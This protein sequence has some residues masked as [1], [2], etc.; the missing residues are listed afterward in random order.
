MAE[1][2]GRRGMRVTVLEKEWQAG[3]L[4]RR[5]AFMGCRFD[6]APLRATGATGGGRI[7]YKG[8]LFSQPV[9]IAEALLNLGPKEAA[10]CLWSLCQTRWRAQRSGAVVDAR[11]AR[12][13]ER[14]FQIFVSNYDRKLG[15]SNRSWGRAG[16]GSAPR[17]AG[18]GCDVWLGHEALALRHAGGRV[19]AAVTGEG[20]GRS[21]DV[22]GS[23]FIS[24]IPV[25][26]L[27]ARLSP[28]APDE[29]LLAAEALSYR[30]LISVN[31]VLDRAE[32]I[33]D[34]WIEVHD[35]AVHAAR[36][37]NFKNVSPDMVSDSGLS[38]LG[39][40]YFC[41]AGDPIWRLSD[42]EMLDLARS[43]LVAMDLCRPD[44]V[45]A[46]FVFRND[47][48]LPLGV[49]GDRE[50]RVLIG[51]WLSKVARNLFCVGSDAVPLPREGRYTGRRSGVAQR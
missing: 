50:R 43:E 49:D 47:R 14:L 31:L 3:G 26:D 35:P 25:P 20:A 10:L 8:R 34:P 18:T 6:L 38:G 13:G 1:A 15:A 12:L 41:S 27:V 4:A 5:V 40:E 42:A 7:L 36:I 37:T 23:A 16:Q 39:I 28:R 24:T 21:V 46:G 9:R 33:P 17:S 30:A 2:L 32:I 22:M 19:L 48:A 44:E 51:S 45:K 29:I 11:L